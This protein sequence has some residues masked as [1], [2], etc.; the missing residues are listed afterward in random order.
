MPKYKVLACF[1]LF[2]LAIAASCSSDEPTARVV[3]PEESLFED[4]PVFDKVDKIREGLAEDQVDN[5]SEEVIEID[6]QP[7]EQSIAEQ[8]AQDE[9]QTLAEFNETEEVA[10]EI[11]VVKEEPKEEFKFPGTS[12]VN[13]KDGISLAIDKIEHEIKGDNWGKIIGITATVLN[14]GVESFRPRLIVVLYDEK[15]FKEEWFKPKAEIDFGIGALKAGEHTTKDAIVNVAF[16][17]INLT[18]NFRAIL[19][20]A[21]DPG[22]KAKVVVETEFNAIG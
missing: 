17:D 19:T 7:E 9:N 3:S 11:A 15:D 10:E 6:Q 16:N 4:E 8:A 22:N 5:Q 13:T 20:D 14:Q 1:F 2:V 21:D 12:I 18:K